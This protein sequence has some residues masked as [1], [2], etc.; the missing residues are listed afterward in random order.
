MKINGFQVEEHGSG[1][2]LTIRVHV[3][4]D[5]LADDWIG[6]IFARLRSGGDL[7]NDEE[8]H[9]DASAQADDTEE[10]GDE[11]PADSGSGTARASRRRGRKRGVGN[12]DLPSEGASDVPARH[13]RRRGRAA[14]KADT[15]PA[16]DVKKPRRARKAKEEKPEENPTEPAATAGRR[17]RR[18]KATGA[19][20]ASASPSDPS[21][22]AKTAG[23]RSRRGK[24]SGA[25]SASTKSPSEDVSDEDLTRAA[26]L[27]AKDLGSPLVMD[28]LEEFGAEQVRDLNQAQRAEFLTRLDDERAKADA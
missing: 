28:I 8:A 9:P 17:S 5:E 12:D 19:E 4:H 24:A 27:A 22:T 20:T 13:T 21:E 16:A 18:G 25:K 14:A 26:S 6:N 7:F 3:G 10:E 15:V 11:A 1:Y 23:R 2:H